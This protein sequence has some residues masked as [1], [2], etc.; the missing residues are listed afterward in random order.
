[1]FSSSEGRKGEEGYGG[2]RHFG[3]FAK[4]KAAPGS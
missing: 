2:G 1:M 3:L 4:I